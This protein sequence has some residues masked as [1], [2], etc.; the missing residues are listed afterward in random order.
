MGATHFLPRIVGPQ[1]ASRLILTG[2][3]IKGAEAERIGMVA[4]CCETPEETVEAAIALATR[5]SAQGPLAVRSAVR[6]LRLGQDDGLDRSLW[7]EAGAQ[8]E[9]W[10]SSDLTEGLDALV[11][12]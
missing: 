10:N 9:H 12:R 6:S 5:I 4:E 1:A 8:A 7:R 2:D 11:E 3:I